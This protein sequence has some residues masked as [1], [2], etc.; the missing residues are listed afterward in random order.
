MKYNV[1]IHVVL[2][3]YEDMEDM[4]DDPDEASERLN[5]I[6]HAIYDR[7]EDDIETSRLEK[8]LQFTWENWQQDKLL[9]DIDDDELLDWV[10]H[11]LATWDDA[12]NTDLS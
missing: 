10:D 11:T 4:H 1:D 5:F 12:D 6:L 3:T 9:L 7:A 8:I 2:S